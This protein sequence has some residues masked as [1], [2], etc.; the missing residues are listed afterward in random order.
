MLQKVGVIQVVAR[1]GAEF[2]RPLI[3]VPNLKIL[4]RVITHG[5]QDDATENERN[6]VTRLYNSRYS[7]EDRPGRIGSPLLLA[8]AT[9]ADTD[10]GHQYWQ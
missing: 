4:T 3:K 9:R 8:Q 2:R 5:E 6:C 1:I 7:P 10:V